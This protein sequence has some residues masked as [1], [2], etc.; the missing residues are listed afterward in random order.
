MIGSTSLSFFSSSWKLSNFVVKRIDVSYYWSCQEQSMSSMP[1]KLWRW[2]MKEWVCGSYT[3]PSYSITCS[4]QDLQEKSKYTFSFLYCLFATIHQQ[5]NS[6]NI[7]QLSS[8]SWSSNTSFGWK[9]CDLSTCFSFYFF[10]DRWVELLPSFDDLNEQ[11]GIDDIFC[12]WFKG[13][14]GLI[15]WWGLSRIWSGLVWV[16]SVLMNF[17]G[18]V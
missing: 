13:T 14:S 6:W 1:T 16:G 12:G 8:Q 18:G 5:F 3:G 4:W 15:F 9:I 2:S 7:S 17:E 11:W 10:E